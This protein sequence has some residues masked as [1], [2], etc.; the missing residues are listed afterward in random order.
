[1]ENKILSN[2]VDTFQ[3]KIKTL[4]DNVFFYNE[5]SSE[6][7]VNYLAR[8][9]DMDEREFTIDDLSTI[10]RSKIRDDVQSLNLSKKLHNWTILGFIHYL[11][12]DAII[13][14]VFLSTNRILEIKSEGKDNK[15]AMDLQV[16]RYL[17]GSNKKLYVLAIDRLFSNY[18]L[19]PTKLLNL[20]EIEETYTDEEIEDKLISRTTD[21][22]L[23]L[24]SKKTPERCVKIKWH[25]RH[26]KNVNMTCTKYCNYSKSCPHM[27][28][29][30]FI[31]VDTLLD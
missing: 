22:D 31:S 6:L 15:Y 10:L 27:K 23:A 29:S 7:L 5:L 20:I 2:F 3:P 24:S 17:D 1:M 8:I 18:R 14:P 13:L 9:G 26:G 28:K 11:R 19:M 30:S 16:L 25:R 12:D 21:L 4:P